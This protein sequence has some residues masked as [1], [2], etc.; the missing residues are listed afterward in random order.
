MLG[1]HILKL[2]KEKKITLTKLASATKLSAGYLS[3]IEHGIAEPSL[4]SL[5][6]IADALDIPA[7]LLLGNTSDNRIY[8]V[9]T[10]KQPTVNIPESSTVQY[11]LC[12]PL[13]SCEFVPCSLLLEFMLQPHSQDFNSPISHNTEEL[14]VI[15]KGEVTVMKANDE[16]IMHTGDTLVLQKN[17]PHIFINRSDEMVFGYCIMTPA[18]W[19]LQT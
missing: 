14:I 15:T 13:P 16:I 9:P 5:H 18:I 4:N 7:M 2:R 12:S 11:R 6:K 1:E 3:Q 10:D 19:S 17:I 8:F